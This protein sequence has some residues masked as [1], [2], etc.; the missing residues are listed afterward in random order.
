MYMLCV[1]LLQLAQCAPTAVWDIMQQ[2]QAAAALACITPYGG[3]AAPA[4]A[5]H[6]GETR[7]WHAPSLPVHLQQP[8]MVG[9]HEAFIPITLNPVV[10]QGWW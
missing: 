4:P 3:C 2:L 6:Q 1:L 9:S 10:W 8:S 7:G 5:E